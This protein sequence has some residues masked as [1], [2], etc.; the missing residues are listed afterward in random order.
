MLWWRF[1]VVETRGYIK[2]GRVS[3]WQVTVNAG[4]RLEV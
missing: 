1:E 3:Y 2:E 4:S